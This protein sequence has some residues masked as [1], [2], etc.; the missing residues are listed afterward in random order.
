MHQGGEDATDEEGRKVI[1]GIA[2]LLMGMLLMFA[3]FAQQ[4]AKGMV[5]CLLMGV[6]FVAAGLLVVCYKLK[7]K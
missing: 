5:A 1:E 6:F 3:A 2:C 7:R 4:E